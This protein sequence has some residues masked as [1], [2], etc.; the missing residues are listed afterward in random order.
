MQGGLCSSSAD[1][2]QGKVDKHAVEPIVLARKHGT[3]P[4]TD[5]SKLSRVTRGARGSIVVLLRWQP[6]NIIH[7]R[8]TSSQPQRDRTPFSAALS[9][10]KSSKVR[11]YRPATNAPKPRSFASEKLRAYRLDEFFADCRAPQC[12]A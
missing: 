11:H 12:A 1:S 4:M 3:A 6:V 7:E 2:T 5:D 9:V 8:L 10:G